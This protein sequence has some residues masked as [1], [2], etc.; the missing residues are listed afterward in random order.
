MH[1][2]Q[3]LVAV[4]A[5]LS[6]SSFAVN[7]PSS[8]LEARD[9][10]S[11]SNVDNCEADLRWHKASAFCSSFAA[12]KDA[13][14]TVYNTKQ[15]KTTCTTKTVACTTPGAHQSRGKRE[16]SAEPVA[17]A[18]ADAEAEA[19]YGYQRCNQWGIPAYFLKY[20][21]QDIKQACCRYVKPKTV[22]VRKN[23]L[24]IVS[25]ETVTPR[26]TT[27]TS[28][29]AL[30]P[31]TT[32]STS[33]TR[34]GVTTTTRTTA[35]ASTTGKGTS[36]TTRSI[37]STTTASGVT[38]SS[39][40]RTSTIPETTMTTTSTT[41]SFTTTSTTASAATTPAASAKIVKN[42]GFEETVASPGGPPNIAAW[43]ATNVIAQ[44]PSEDGSPHS[45]SYFARFRTNI[46]KSAAS[47]SQAIDSG[48]SGPFTLTYLSRVFTNARTDGYTC[49]F[50]T[51]L[52]NVD[53]ATRTFGYVDTPSTVDWQPTTI[54][55]L[56]LGQGKVLEFRLS[57]TYANTYQYLDFALDDVQISN[58]GNTVAGST[59]STTTTAAST[60]TTAPV[61]T[62]SPP[63]CNP[64]P[65]RTDCKGRPCFTRPECR[66]GV[67]NA[68]EC[69]EL[70]STTPGVLSTVYQDDGTCVLYYSC[71]EATEQTCNIFNVHVEGAG[72]NYAINSQ[73][74]GGPISVL[75]SQQ[76]ATQYGI[77][78]GG[79]I[80]TGN[81]VLWT[82][83]FGQPSFVAARLRSTVAASG[84][85]S[86]R[87][88]LTKTDATSRNPGRL[89][90]LN[91]AA[92]SIS[93]VQVCTSEAGDPALYLGDSVRSDCTS[94][95]LSAE[96]VPKSEK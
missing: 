49:T 87:C 54:D 13:T 42:G 64:D 76:G 14:T 74:D 93:A 89:A 96:C 81:N 94:V 31:T 35:R 16:A 88:T 12:I 65:L 3:S 69:Q 17:A 59:T 39:S 77:T 86:V 46:D 33:T 58:P 5:L 90:C 60:T 85:V 92:S 72:F 52:N 6:T 2:L 32:R 24:T 38:T 40:T 22:V 9:L 70:K 30:V 80:F 47:L 63:S 62:T 28:R 78:E 71:C 45:G 48:A 21:C 67:A 25:T 55:G 20:S 82:S 56:T 57:C 91:G 26:C 83:A 75:S 50:T 18:V 43:T 29:G 36:S 23:Q 11:R 27:T 44:G 66:Q 1:F 34:T 51:R 37:A 68:E 41:M 7:I 8:P 15:P 10:S 61:S 84:D 73:S 95:T 79:E 19:H 53:I 4:A